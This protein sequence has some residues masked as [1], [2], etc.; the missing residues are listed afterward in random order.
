MEGRVSPA[1]SACAGGCAVTRFTSNV[2]KPPYAVVGPYSTSVLLNSFVVHVN[3]APDDVIAVT[4]TAE[5]T[6]GVV[7]AT[8]TELLVASRVN[9]PL[10]KNR[11]S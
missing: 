8:V 6:G 10:A 2:L 7:S 9:P 5:I 1:I 3:V 11:T 4:L